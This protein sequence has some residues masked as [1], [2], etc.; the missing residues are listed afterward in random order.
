MAMTIE[1]PDGGVMYYQPARGD[2][3]SL[4]DIVQLCRARGMTYEEIAELF[5]KTIE[6]LKGEQNGV[7]Q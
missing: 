7:V 4:L 6:R 2:G 5:E 3:K 1:K